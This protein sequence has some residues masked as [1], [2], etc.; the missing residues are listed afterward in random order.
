MTDDT[1][2]EKKEKNEE[3]VNEG[4]GS[5]LM[6]EKQFLLGVCFFTL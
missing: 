6:R 4:R 1:Q 2:T 3:N 5:E